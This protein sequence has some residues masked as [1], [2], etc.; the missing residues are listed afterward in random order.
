[1]MNGIN[2]GVYRNNNLNFIKNNQ[3][4]KREKNIV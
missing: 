3:V 4:F 1:M 2:S